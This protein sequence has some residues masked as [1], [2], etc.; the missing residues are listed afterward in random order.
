M[1]IVIVSDIFGKTK[2]LEKLALNINNNTTILDPYGGSFLNFIDEKSA[3]KYFID[4]IGL[5]LYTK[6]LKDYIKAQTDS[7][8]L[9]GFSIGS[10]AI[11]NISNDKTLKN[12]KKTICFYGSQIRYKTQLEPLFPMELIFPL[13]EE[14][15][16]VE[17]LILKLSNKKN[18][19]IRQVQY[20]HGFMN[21]KSLNFNL[22]A[23]ELELNNLIND[24]D[25]K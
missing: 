10:S 13:K 5:D 22:D 23:Y 24:L 11:W 4:T 2:A 1:K 21:E 3:Y 18:I 16:S 20:L 7:V 25:K 19:S 17:E 15:F 14:H 6:K 9:I 12:I 8:I